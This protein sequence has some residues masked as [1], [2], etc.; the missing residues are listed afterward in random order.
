M[1][2]DEK[3]L[4]WRIRK[5]RQRRAQNGDLITIMLKVHCDSLARMLAACGLI[6]PADEDSPERMSAAVR[7]FV[8]MFIDDRDRRD[9]EGW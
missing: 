3:R 2:E 1:T 9:I 5:R 7:N 4:R 8:K 6:S